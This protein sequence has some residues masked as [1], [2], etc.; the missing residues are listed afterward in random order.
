MTISQCVQDEMCR[1]LRMVGLAKDVVLPLV[2][3]LT[4]QVRA[5]GPENVVKRLKEIKLAAVNHIAG[6]TSVRPKWV[7]HTRTGLKGPWKPVWKML[8]GNYRQRKRALNAMMVYAQF[9][10]PK[11][12]GPTPTQEKKFI[13]SCR[14]DPV[15]LE[16]R[17]TRMHEALRR[18]LAVKGFKALKRALHG[19]VDCT[20]LPEPPEIWSFL[21]RHYGLDAKSVHRLEKKVSHFLGSDAGRPFHAFPS[22]QKFLGEVGEDY[23]SL[24]APWNGANWDWR[25]ATP[26]D[27]PIG[28]I[29][30]AQEPGF[31]FRA[32]AAP[33]P[34]LQGAL[35]P[36]KERLQECLKVL[37]WDCTNDQEKGVRTVQSWLREGKTVFSVDLSDATNN[38]PLQLQTMVLKGLGVPQE[39]IN[40]LSLVS[41]A[42]Y[43]LTWKKDGET[44]AW[45]YG[46]PLGSGPSFMCFALAHAVVALDAEIAAGVAPQDLGTTFRL[47]GD[48]FVTCNP[49]VHEEYRARMSALSVPI[50]EPKCLV[51][52]IAGEFAGKVIMKH[53]VFHGYKYKEV[54]DLSFLSVIRTLGPQAISQSL[55]TEQQYSYAVLVKELPEPYGLGFNPNGRPLK[56]R[57]E[58]YLVLSEALEEL[59]RNQSK[60]TVAEMKNKVLCHM[61]QRQ[62][63][64]YPQY[65]DEVKDS[66]IPKDRNRVISDVSIMEMIRGAGLIATQKPNGDPRPNPIQD[67]KRKYTRVV[68]PIVKRLR[69]SQGHS[70]VVSKTHE[71]SS[72]APTVLQVGET[73]PERDTP[74][75]SDFDHFAPERAALARRAATT[76]ELIEEE[77]TS[78]VKV[79][80]LSR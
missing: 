75:K 58:E 16:A 55:L 3:T 56:D 10:L 38:F 45:N 80:T 59:K 62:Y 15:T 78:Q 14:L 60:A 48:D 43:K 29:G 66:Q 47:L 72:L 6:H 71:T 39:A 22:V 20:S 27:E 53:Q 65:R 63:W 32:F 33:S 23:F 4:R 17:N 37:P 68:E 31:K 74:E 1:K 2:N 70:D 21:G 61:T 69:E 42:E 51:S 46:Q 52:D 24:T 54:S 28:V 36:L 34:V 5:E 79:S 26:S 35:Q 73:I 9:V 30:S 11:G 64:Y 18:G 7:A 50:S 41:R 12:T 67:W 13:G 76:L 40:L 49:K 19:K 25:E 77:Q 44:I 57:C 8:A